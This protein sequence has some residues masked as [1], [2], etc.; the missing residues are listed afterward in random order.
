MAFVDAESIIK[1]YNIII[2]KLLASRPLCFVNGIL[3]LFVTD[4]FTAWMSISLHIEAMLFLI[5]KLSPVTPIIL[6]MPWF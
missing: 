5:A 1:K 2:K 3:T 4:Y 6:G